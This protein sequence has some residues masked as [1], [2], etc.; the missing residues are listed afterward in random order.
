MASVIFK[1]GCVKTR[2]QAVLFDSAT[3]FCPSCQK[4]TEKEEE[5]EERREKMHQ[6]NVQRPKN[7]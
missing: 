6:T 4:E 5:E 2:L 3:F 7:F 1:I